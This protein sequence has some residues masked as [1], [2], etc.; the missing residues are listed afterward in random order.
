MGNNSET[1]TYNPQAILDDI[2][3][4]SGLCYF[5]RVSAEEAGSETT[6]FYVAQLS[7][8]TDDIF[9]NEYFIQ[10]VKTTDGGAPLNE[11]R[12]VSD[13][14][15]AS[16]KFVVSSAFS[17]NVNTNDYILLIH[18]SLIAM[19]R[20][21]ANN[22]FD[23]SSVVANE[24]G[25]ALERL[26]F[27]QENLVPDIWGLVYF[28]RC[29]TGM[30]GSTTSIVC[31]EL[32]GK[33]DDV[34]NTKYY[35]QVI[36]N[37]NSVGNAPELQVR[38]ITDYE[39]ATGTFTV[40]AFGA[41]VEEGDIILVMHES[42]ATLGRDDADNTIATTNVVANEDG[43]VL[44]RL[45]QIQEA[46]NVGT[47]TSMAANSS[48]ADALGTDAATVTDSA[49]TVIGPMGAN[50]ADNAFASNLV[51]ADRDG[52]ILERSEFIMD[53]MADIDTR[54]DRIDDNVSDIQ[55]EV[56]DLSEAPQIKTTLEDLA[57]ME[58]SASGDRYVRVEA[59]FQDLDG[60]MA[61]PYTNVLGVY[62]IDSA[63]NNLTGNCYKDIAGVAQ[64]DL[65]GGAGDLSAYREL[66]RTAQGDY[67]FFYKVGSTADL[68]ELIYR[69]GWTDA[70]LYYE[71]T[72]YSYHKVGCQ[73]VSP[74]NVKA[75][76]TVSK[77]D[78]DITSEYEITTGDELVVPVS[79]LYRCGI[80]AR[81]INQSSAGCK[82]TLR[83]VYD[84]GS[85]DLE[86]YNDE[87]NISAGETSAMKTSNPFWVPASGTVKVYI[88]SDDANDDTV[89]LDTYLI[90]GNV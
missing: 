82:L 69:F 5:G 35:M 51:V 81:D 67:F 3:A 24:D 71:D 30:T 77:T 6:E 22:I 29:D 79:Q 32:G 19:G 59:V 50:N 27:I 85:I 74:V 7:G 65:V 13:Y 9:N 31:A 68:E 18:E 46:T 87:V 86:V 45:E 60:D 83:V 88:T 73:I 41:K 80:R 34:F 2:E 15:S 37:T 33:G 14:V 12:K 47:G 26:Q 48:I 54:I 64:L 38:Q 78:Q 36:R 72:E 8:W 57:F 62:V 89:D 75:V 21:D 52:S 4:T 66:E 44:E 1:H 40:T 20:N 16:G 11:V 25:S 17:A 43:S 61:D 53:E 56:E 55:D 63:G 10:L 58:R 23:S 76:D 28:G 90:E 70:Q 39:S 84:D 42:L 49:V